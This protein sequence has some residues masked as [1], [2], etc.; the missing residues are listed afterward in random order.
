MMFRGKRLAWLAI[1]ASFAVLATPGSVLHKAGASTTVSTFKA[2][3]DAYA[4]QKQPTNI[5]GT[6]VKA[7]LQ[8][9]SQAASAIGYDVRSVADNT[10]GETTITFQNAPPPSASVVGS[11]GPL[12]SGQSV[13]VD[14][15]SVVK[16]NGLISVAL[17]TTST[18]GITLSSREASASVVPQLVVQT[19]SDVP[20]AH[21]AV[22]TIS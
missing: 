20:P 5:S 6:V 18:T 13:S 1:P 7:T 3:A 21:T 22:R 4:F 10:W 2:A 15:K 9:T 14:L 12:N 19:T 8:L 16:G 11:S 17:T